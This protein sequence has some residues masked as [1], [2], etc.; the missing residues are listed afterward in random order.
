MLDLIALAFWTDQTRIASFMFGNAVSSRSFSFLGSEFGGHHQTSHHEKKEDK[1]AQYQRIN[2][3]HM[4]HLAYFLA[5]LKSIREG[6]GTLLDNSMI[7][8]GAGMRDGNSHNPHNLPIVVAGRG[9]GALATGRHLRYSANTPLTNLYR[10]MLG[11]MGTPVS[12]F[13]DS[14]GE[15]RGLNDAAFRGEPAESPSSETG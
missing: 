6:E 9:G 3:W 7:V 15:L 5:K 8:F 10:S 4:E 12:R 2:A 13:A 1:L 14:T 11:A